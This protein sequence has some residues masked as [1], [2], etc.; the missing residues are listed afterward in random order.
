VTTNVMGSHMLYAL[1]S[2]CNFSFSGPHFDYSKEYFFGRGNPHNFS[3]QYIDKLL[4]IY[5]E[6]FIKINFARFVTNNPKNGLQDFCFAKKEI[7]MN[8]ILPKNRVIKI[9]GWDLKGQ[10]LGYTKGGV[11][12]IWRHI[13]SNR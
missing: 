10:L 6:N 1:Y 5:S 7:G 9:L 2:G 3:D 13:S 11:R 12:R 8:N 4:W